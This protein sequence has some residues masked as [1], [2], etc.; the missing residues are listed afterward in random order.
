M[1]KAIL[2]ATLLGMS[3][4]F[5]ACKKVKLEKDVPRCVEKK[6]RK[7]ANQKEGSSQAVWEWQTNGQRYYY[8]IGDC[9]DQFN[10]L[11]D[12]DCNQICAPDGGFSGGGDGKCPQF[13]AIEKTLIWR[14]E[15]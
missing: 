5:I 15:R 1:K 10:Y 9:C 13:G 12:D 11:Y 14:D 8:F 3:T 7:I 2:A 4:A 6:I